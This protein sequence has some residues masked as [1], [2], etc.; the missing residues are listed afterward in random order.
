MG[1]EMAYEWNDRIPALLMINPPT[2]IEGVDDELVCRVPNGEFRPFTISLVWDSIRDS[3]NLCIPKHAFNLWLV[4]NSKLKTQDRLRQWDV[5]PETD[6]NLLRCLFC[7]NQL[8]SHAHLFF[9][10]PLSLQ[11]GTRVRALGRMDNIPPRLEDVVSY[12]IPLSK[13]GS[14]TSVISHLLLAASCYSIWHE[15]NSRLFKKGMKSYTQ[16]FDDIVTIVWLKIIS[17]RFTMN[18]SRI[19]RILDTWRLPGSVIIASSSTRGVPGMGCTLFPYS[20]VFPFRFFL[21]KGF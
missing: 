2:L 10:C 20:K 7:D 14:A 16:V 6:L 21:G 13:G 18:S 15:R 1:L 3:A 4:V 12:L 9:E 11:G 17:F 5:G 8:D 19:R